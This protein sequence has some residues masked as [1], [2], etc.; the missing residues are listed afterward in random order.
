MSKPTRTLKN[1]IPW[2]KGVELISGSNHEGASQAFFYR[3]G[4]VGVVPQGKFKAEKFTLDDVAGV[5]LSAP[6]G[7]VTRVSSGGAR[8]VERSRAASCWV[9]LA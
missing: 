6:E 8:R 4:R 9:L 1:V 5:S 7:A 3:D 2:A